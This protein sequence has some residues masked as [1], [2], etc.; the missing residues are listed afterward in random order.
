MDSCNSKRELF[1]SRLGFILMTAGCAIGL[2]N[3]W[4]F[5]YITGQYFHRQ[6]FAVIVFAVSDCV[7]VPGYAYG[8]GIGEGIALYLSRCLPG[9]EK[10]GG[11]LSLAAAGTYSFLRK[12]YTVDFLQCYNR[13]ASD[14]QR[15]IYHRFFAE[16]F[17]RCYAKCFWCYV[18][19]SGTTGSSNADGNDP[20][21]SDLCRRLAQNC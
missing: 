17:R 20:D 5:S 11:A 4:R 9:I 15:Q 19:C 7:G 3:V 6:L 16:S 14:L 12:H 13:L 2:G 10:S 18:V 1:A 8:T 21:S